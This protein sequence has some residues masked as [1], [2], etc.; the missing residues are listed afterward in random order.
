MAAGAFS[1]KKGK[2]PLMP[3][4]AVSRRRVR[5]PESCRRR[6]RAARRAYRPATKANVTRG[7]FPS[8][9]L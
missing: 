8:A 6:A 1:R 3:M 7:L 4:A 5:A 9:G 2:R